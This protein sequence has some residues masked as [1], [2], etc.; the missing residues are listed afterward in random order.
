MLSGSLAL[1]QQAPPTGYRSGVLSPH[2]HRVPIVPDRWPWS[3]I[4]RVN[5]I[6]G[7]KRSFCTGTLIGPRHVITA[8]HCLFDGKINQFVK[9]QAIHFVAAQDREKFAAHA[10]ATALVDLP[11]RLPAMRECLRADTLPAAEPGS[12]CGNPYPCEFWDRCTADKP[13][14]WVP[15]MP[16]LS[17]AR[18]EDLKALG[19]ETI[20]AIPPD[21]P[22]TTRQAIIRDAIAMGRPFVAPD[23]ARLLQPTGRRPVTSISRR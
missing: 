12:Q 19:I 2:D 4:G 22:L 1:A 11:G 20:P 10:V 3:S 6:M 15:Y 5:V 17:Q 23:L 9:P 16:R 13:A 7:L 8:A 14:D 21:F 18:V